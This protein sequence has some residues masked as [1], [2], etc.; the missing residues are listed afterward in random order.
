VGGHTDSD[1]AAAHNEELST[2]R[3]RAVADHLI[4][5]GIREERVEAKGYGASTPIAPNDTDENK[6]RNRRTEV[7]V[8]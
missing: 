2:A 8:L 5:N 1:G 6:R 7:R 4:A 3:A